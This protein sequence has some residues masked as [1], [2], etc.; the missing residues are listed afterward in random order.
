MA[1]LNFKI[2]IDKIKQV[3]I[4]LFDLDCNG[5]ISLNELLIIFKS[6]II[7]FCRLTD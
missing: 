6:V 7:G 3:L 5:S 4:V 2:S 1:L